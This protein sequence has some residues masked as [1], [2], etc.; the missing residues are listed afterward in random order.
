MR[1][2]ITDCRR[3][4][5][6]DYR[7][8]SCAACGKPFDADSDIVICPECG[9]PHHRDCWKE[10][11]QCACAD[12]HSEGYEWE[13]ARIII[14]GSKETASDAQTTGRFEDERVI[15]PICGN[16][17]LKSEKYC[18]RCG[19][20]LAHDREG[21]YAEDQFAEF[22]GLF[23]FDNA[24]PIEG[25]PA[26]DVKR[27]VGGMWMYYIP[28]FIR[29]SRKQGSL[30][31]NFTAFL[32]HGLWFIS[33]KMYAVGVFLTLMMAGISSYQ[34]YFYR[35][36][37][38]LTGDKLLFF[39]SLYFMFSGFEFL[40]MILSGIFGNKIYMKFC[41]RKIKKI[42]AKAVAQHATAEQFNE[43]VEEEGG[44]ALLQTLSVSVCYLAVLYILRLG[45]LF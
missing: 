8:M 34:V 4:F 18:E 6:K 33:R 23:D 35:I 3:I 15:C 27:F 44:I 1:Q 14:G 39:T 41:A 36:S 12:K 32:M 5:M 19:Y 37:N 13:P 11:G 30:T 43:A 40:V 17:T 28:R 10:A 22:E 7:N 2:H 16:E 25:V 24:E 29:M 42:N 45:I 38:D 21:A 26:G 9:A 31:F 20:Y